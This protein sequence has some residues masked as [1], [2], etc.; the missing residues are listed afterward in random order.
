MLERGSAIR[1]RLNRVRCMGLGE[2]RHRALR[3]LTLRAERWGLGSTAAVPAPD[4]AQ[5]SRAWIHADAKVDAAS[6][7]SAAERIAG[8]RLDVFALRDLD[9]GSP[10]RWNRDPKTGVDAPLT[11]G[12]L[13]DYRDPRRV[14]DIKYLWEPNRHH[15]LVTLAQA[16]ALGGQPRHFGVIRRH[17]QSWFASCPHAMGPNWSSALEAAIRLINWSAAWQ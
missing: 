3:S 6:Y 4:L 12:M 7:L 13:L 1:W 10:P 8:G 2:I 15:H 9:L 16:Y 11:F 14:G 17:L 5:T